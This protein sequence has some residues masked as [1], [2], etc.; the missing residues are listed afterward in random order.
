MK[1]KNFNISINSDEISDNI[2]ESI[3]FLI[4]HK[5]K[6]IEI[7]TINGENIL[8]IPNQKIKK[9]AQ[10]IKKSGL[11]V[12]AIASPLF[13]WY[14]YP[15]TKK[16]Q[17]DTFAFSPN[18]N[19]E[20]KIRYISKAITVANIFETKLVRV[21]SNLKQ[22]GVTVENLYEDKIFD[23]MLTSF[24]KS[25]ITPLLENEPVCLVSQKIDYLN[26]LKR[27]KKNGLM[28]WWDIANSY[29]VDGFIDNV[30]IKQ[31][32]PLLK[33]IHIKDEIKSET[34]VY[35]PMG[36]GIINYKRIFS[37]L[38][39]VITQKA[40][41][42]LETHV[43]SEKKEATLA[44]LKY[45]RRI[46]TQKRIIYSI[47]GAGNIAKN[48]IKAL[49]TNFNSE[50]RGV[51]DIDLKKAKVFAKEH[52]IYFYPTL[53]SLLSESKTR[54]VNICTPHRTHMGIA[55][56]CL[57][58]NK[59]V[60]SEKPFAL[61]TKSLTAFL[62]NKKAGQNTYI[63]FQNL[64]NPPIKKL[65]SLINNNALGTLQFFSINI[66]WCRDNNY[67]KDWHGKLSQSGGS[68][69]NQA[70]HSLQIID[71]I[72][73]NQIKKVSYSKKTFAS[74]SEVEDL[75]VATF[76]SK[77]GILGYMEMCLIN[78]GGNIESSLY[79]VGDKGSI[80]IGGNSLNKMIYQFYPSL[81]TT[82]KDDICVVGQVYG[83]GHTRLIRALSDKLLN[84]KN[85]DI[86]KLITA[87][88]LFPVINLIEK[89][90]GSKRRPT[91]SD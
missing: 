73:R 56:K 84:N 19:D 28:A 80:K 57:L 90:Y 91:T 44:S 53:K 81:P 50:C 14:L 15:Q 11:K 1:S 3:K 31:V 26:T 78:K 23:L 65:F 54:V 24:S 75:G 52:D 64:F 47:I 74:N 72:F 27:Y 8:N 41:I 70:I 40:F 18:L 45:L 6:F 59:L 67:F 7:R 36:T 77:K 89:M 76:E 79:L 22:K 63:V 13:K 55:K 5:V 66:R 62:K 39:D 71:L 86:N 32:A 33:Y 25:G 68:L 37:D 48:H 87:K 21:F 35:V 2:D 61:S 51:F 83:D 12:S 17:I 85:E 29:D 20:Q 69:F 43:A 58:Q 38:N 49:K 16:G 82:T 4:H 9:I 30:Y 34:K 88:Q 60:L 46:Y 42:S 10:K